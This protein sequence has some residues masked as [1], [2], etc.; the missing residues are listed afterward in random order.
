MMWCNFIEQSLGKSEKSS[1]ET[2]QTKKYFLDLLQLNNLLDYSP[3]KLK[4][5]W[6]KF[7]TRRDFSPFSS[8]S[9]FRWISCNK[10]I[11]KLKLFKLLELN[12]SFKYF[13]RPIIRINLF[14]KQT[15]IEASQITWKRAK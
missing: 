7:S 6:S 15:V 2:K 3:P 8:F 9:P 4:I 10:S 11:R 1:L 12:S 5:I 14:E 13:L